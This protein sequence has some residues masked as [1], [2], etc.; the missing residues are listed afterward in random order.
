ML[1]RLLASFA[2]LLTMTCS[3]MAGDAPDITTADLEAAI[4]AKTVTIID[5]NGSKS[6]AAGHIPGAVDFATAKADLAKVL[7][8]D[9][10]ALIVAY[11]GGP[12]CHAYEAAVTAAEKLGYTNIKHYSQGIRGWKKEGKTVATP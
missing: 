9:K 2:L 3:L 1:S 11:C 5:V 10:K 6:Y 7:P 12:Q 4:A 8:A